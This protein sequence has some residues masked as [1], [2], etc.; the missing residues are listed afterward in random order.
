MYGIPGSYI[1]ISQSQLM[2]LIGLIATKAPPNFLKHEAGRG[3]D[4]KITLT[5]VG[6]VCFPTCDVIA[7]SDSERKGAIQSNSR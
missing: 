5:E 4:T 1:Y 7:G 6:R 2:R 3:L